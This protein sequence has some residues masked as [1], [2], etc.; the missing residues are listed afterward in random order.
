MVSR[1]VVA[2][3]LNGKWKTLLDL[4]HGRTK[5]N[6]NN[7]DALKNPVIAWF[8][9][10]FRVDRNRNYEQKDFPG[11]EIGM[12]PL[13]KEGRGIGDGCIFRMVGKTKEY[14]FECG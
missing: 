7:P 9:I 13:S 8:E 11:L 14:Y 3:W 6:G 1:L 4:D 2:K 10:D 5:V 12:A